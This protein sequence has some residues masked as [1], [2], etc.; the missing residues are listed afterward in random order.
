[1]GSSSL[2]SPK[3]VLGELSSLAIFLVAGLILSRDCDGDRWGDIK[4]DRDGV[5]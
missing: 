3:L 2:F 5:G 1:M 4:T